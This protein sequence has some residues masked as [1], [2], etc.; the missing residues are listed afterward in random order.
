MALQS[1]IPDSATPYV[2]PTTKQCNYSVSI[3]NNLTSSST[4]AALSANQGRLLNQKIA[5]LED[6]K[7]SVSNGKRLLA[8]AITD[9]GVATS[10]SDTFATMAAN[11][12]KIKVSTTPTI[13]GTGTADLDAGD[14]TTLPGCVYVEISLVYPL[15]MFPSSATCYAGNTISMIVAIDDRGPCRATFMLDETGSGLGCLDTEYHGSAP[16]NWVAYG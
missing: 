14:Y 3:I 15:P 7:T 13:V 2:H 4:S 9:K 1:D 10:S 11:I 8:N 16:I 12:A 6:L 5:K